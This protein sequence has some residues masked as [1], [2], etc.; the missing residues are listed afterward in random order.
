[1]LRLIAAELRHRRGRALALLAGIAVA[2]ASFTVLTGASESSRLEVR[3]DVA[4]HFRT[5]YD[6]LVR[7]RGSMS[8]LE[9]SEGLVQQNFLA[10]SFGGITMDQLKTVRHAP[11]VEVAAPLA[12]YG[13]VMPTATIRLPVADRLDAGKRSLFR[14]STR[15][16]AD[17]G[18]VRVRDADSYIYVT[19]NPIQ[20]ALPGPVGARTRTRA[21]ERFSAASYGSICPTRSSAANAF[22]PAARRWMW[23]W[24]T[25]GTLGAGDYPP[26]HH[27][28]SDVGAQIQYPFPLLVA[29]IDPQAEAALS[30][31]DRAVVSGRWFRGDEP[32]QV[33]GKTATK[34]WVVPLLAASSTPTSLRA[35][36]VVEHLPTAAADALAH[37]KGD[38]PRADRVLAG[39]AGT[40]VLR[41]TV[42]ANDAYTSLLRQMRTTS[43]VSALWTNGPPRYTTVG[44]AHVR[45]E[46]VK[47]DRFAWGAQSSLDGTGTGFIQA[48]ILGH[49]TGFRAFSEHIQTSVNPPPFFTYTKVVGTFDPNRLAGA[50]NPD[51]A[52]LNPFHPPTAGAADPDAAP[53]LHGR[54]LTPDANPAGYLAAPPALLTTMKAGAAFTQPQLFGR[55]TADQAAAPITAIRV[56]VAGVTGPDKAS[57]ERIRLAAEAIARRTGLQV[58]VTAGS[59][60]TPVDVDLPASR[61]GRPAVTL[62]EGW[63]KKGVATAILN[64]VDRKSLVLFFLVLVVCALFCVNATGAAVRSRSTELGVLAC[65]GW[66]RRQLFLYLLTEVGVVGLAAGVIGLVVAL[67]A[68]AALGLPVGGL[69]AALAVPC[70][71]ALALLAGALPAARAARSDPLEAVRPKVRASGSARAVRTVRGL[72]LRNLVRVPGRSALG[73]VSLGVGVFALTAL[74]AVTAA[75]RGAVVGTVLGDAVA[76]QVRTADYVAVGAALVLGGLAVADVL[77]LNLRDRSAEIATLRATGWRERQLTRLV[78]L[79]GAGLGLVG[80]VGGAVLGLGAATWFTGEL[81][82]T[83]PVVAGAAALLAVAIAVAA[84]I[85]PVAALH[86]MPT[87]TLLAEE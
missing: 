75:F 66:P 70:A 23:C 53:W 44:P 87:A 63:I 45:A 3:G 17:G 28:P 43:F 80:G 52:P 72:A 10:G 57:R 7:P 11:G 12:I 58:D 73:V 21:A 15:W 32:A 54:P 69:R 76:V 38:R 6:V 67:P 26:E 33:L 82:S 4:H 20:A 19:R 56:R 46:E 49:D 78:A 81:T 39:A 60:P 51:V 59:S 48:P 2:T 83:M 40:P 16:T 86:R 22:S 77:Y 36:Y 25:D 68:G 84:S 18:T 50:L 42:T 5:A 85:P 1:M 64:A 34:S 14:V 47:T 41:R 31:T 27:E 8:T 24:S 71:T 37:A 30:G 79:E 74:L 55:E 29:G 61:L 62:R 65:V 35:D 13:W 9:R